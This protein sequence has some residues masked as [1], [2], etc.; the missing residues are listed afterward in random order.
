MP[1]VEF[2]KDGHVAQVRLNRPQSLNAVTPEMDQLLFEAWT[3][4]NRDPEIWVAILSAEGDRAFCAGADVSGNHNGARRRVA[5]GGGITGVGGPLVN[6]T[7]PLIAAVQGHVVGGGFEMAM[8]A[9]IIVAADTAKFSIPETRAGIMG[10]SGIMHRAIRQ[11]PHR[12]A[13][14]MIL[15]GERL[16]A[17]DALRF[18]LV[19]EVVAGEELSEAA[20]RWSDRVLAASPLASQ[21]AKDAVLSRVGHPL[22]VAL[23][24]RYEPIEAYAATQDVLEGRRAFSEKRSPQW[25]GR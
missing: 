10:E 18:G 12:V 25:T 14:A 9:D 11:L 22:E 19:N 17:E 7:K 6:V 16:A 5:F 21:A 20:G 4:V 24:T 8:C 1:D 15:T 2:S 23:S 3:E 13:M